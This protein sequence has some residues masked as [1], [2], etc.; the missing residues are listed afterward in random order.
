LWLSLRVGVP[1]EQVLHFCGELLQQTQV[2][3]TDVPHELI[4]LP[5]RVFNPAY[6]R[7]A[8]PPELYVPRRY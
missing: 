1:V 5:N 8:R 2:P 6:K 7:Q 3:Y 4:T